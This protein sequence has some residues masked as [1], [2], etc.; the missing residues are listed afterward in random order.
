VIAT[1]ECEWKATLQDPEKL[2]RFKS[3]VNTDEADDSIVFERKRGQIR[4]VELIEIKE[5]S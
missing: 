3:F 1:Y 2:K 4:P 5:V